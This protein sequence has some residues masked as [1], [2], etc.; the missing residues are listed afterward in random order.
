MIR[1]LS[2]HSEECELGALAG[3]KLD[4]GGGEG[5]VNTY[6]PSGLCKRFLQLLGDSSMDILIASCITRYPGNFGQNGEVRQV[7]HQ[8]IVSCMTVNTIR[9][10]HGW[11]NA[12]L[13]E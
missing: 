2:E 4:T 11:A 6:P 3:L 1:L 8:I 5:A 7:I 10:Y 13:H 12:C 9:S